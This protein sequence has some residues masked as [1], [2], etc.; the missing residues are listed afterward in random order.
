[1]VHQALVRAGAYR[2]NCFQVESVILEQNELYLQLETSG[3]GQCRST[4]GILGMS[5]EASISATLR[6][7]NG[8]MGGDATPAIRNVLVPTALYIIRTSISVDI[9]SFAGCKHCLKRHI[10][11][12]LVIE[13]APAHRK[14][15][16][17]NIWFANAATHPDYRNR[18][19]FRKY[20]EN[21]K[22]AFSAICD[23]STRLFA[24][25]TAPNCDF[26]R[27]ALCWA[28]RV[29]VERST[30]RFPKVSYM[31]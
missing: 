30:L 17:S 22:Y 12:G 23:R 27:P 24:S 13:A 9:Q 15:C 31:S 25:A 18:F 2:G 29:S 26:R 20:I 5:T 14:T 16:I 6:G 3:L 28:H 11:G 10:R 1:M 7:R 8:P 21:A 4:S 19:L